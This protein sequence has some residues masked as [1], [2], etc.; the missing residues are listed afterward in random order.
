MLR[1]A[2]WA[3]QGDLSKGFEFSLSPTQS[4]VRPSGAPWLSSADVLCATRPNDYEHDFIYA[5]ANVGSRSAYVDLAS[6][7]GKQRAERRTAMWHQ[8]LGF[9]DP[10]RAGSEEEHSLREPAAYDAPSLLGDAHMLAP[11]VTFSATSPRWPDPILVP[12]GSSAPEWTAPSSVGDSG[13]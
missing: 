6:T 2:I 5:D 1:R 8:T 13:G 4:R 12:R 11:P 3:R 7:D 10:E 9:V